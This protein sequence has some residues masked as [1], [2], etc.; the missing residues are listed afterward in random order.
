MGELSG[1]GS[2]LRTAWPGIP[3]EVSCEKP[4]P[5]K[6]KGL[7]RK[8]IF[9]LHFCKQSGQTHRGQTHFVIENLSDSSR[10]KAGVGGCWGKSLLTW[11]IGI[12]LIL[13]SAQRTA[14]PRGSDT[15]AQTGSVWGGARK[16]HL[17]GVCALVSAPTWI[18]VSVCL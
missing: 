15:D 13:E 18:S 10:S 7:H 8:F 5:S 1:L 14:P 17:S 12:R 9:L 16:A 6:Q 11:K 3:P 4:Q 2:H